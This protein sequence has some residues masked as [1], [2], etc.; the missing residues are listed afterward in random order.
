LPNPRAGPQDF[1]RLCRRGRSRH[2]SHRPAA[3]QV[4]APKTHPTIGTYGDRSGGR[5]DI[6][7][8]IH[9][10]CGAPADGSLVASPH[11]LDQGVCAPYARGSTAT[12]EVLITESN[13]PFE[14]CGGTFAATCPVPLAADSRPLEPC[15]RTSS[16]PLREGWVRVWV[17]SLALAG[18]GYLLCYQVVKDRWAVVRDTPASIYPFTVH[19][20]T[21]G[22]TG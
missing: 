22:W 16:F 12:N 20:S 21:N 5:A 7:T 1:T 9:S 8:C 15:P 2:R 14:G 11:F 4:I 17:R 6:N 19:L 13:A 10:A 3:P 18:A